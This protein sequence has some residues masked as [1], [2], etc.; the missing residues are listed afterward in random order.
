MKSLGLEI[1]KIGDM[2][3]GH[4]IKGKKC[5][6]EDDDD[7]AEMYSAVYNDKRH[8][9]SWCYPATTGNVSK[10]QKGGR[11]RKHEDEGDSGSRSKQTATQKKI[12]AIEEIIAKL[13]EIHGGSY[14]VE[15]LNAWAHLIQVGK[16][17]SY[18]SPPNYPYFTGRKKSQMS[19]EGAMSSKYAEGSSANCPEKTNSSVLS[20]GKGVQLRS[21][22]IDQLSRWHSLK[23]EGGISAEEYEQLR[24]N[25]LSDIGKF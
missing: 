21:Q 10:E 16:H 9:V 25:I 4:G 20:P 19:S 1:G 7:V 24:K 2:R 5:L 18:D 14:K 8:I 3:P 11:K 15:H 17:N 22:C 23:Q 6:L 13:K 12:D